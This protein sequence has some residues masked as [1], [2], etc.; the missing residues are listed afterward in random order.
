MA[1]L[2]SWR[3]GVGSWRRAVVLRSYSAT[4]GNKEGIIHKEEKESV[5]EVVSPDELVCLLSRPLTLYALLS[6]VSPLAL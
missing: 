1:F 2:R 5:V 4:A 6:V 3:L